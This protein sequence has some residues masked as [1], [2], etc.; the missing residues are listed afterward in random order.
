MESLP[1]E[2]EGCSSKT[3]KKVQKVHNFL[4]DRLM[5]LKFF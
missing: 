2:N 3:G 4:S 1:G 5:A